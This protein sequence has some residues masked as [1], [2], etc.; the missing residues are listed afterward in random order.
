[1]ITTVSVRADFNTSTGQWDGDVS[2]RSF[3][4]YCRDEMPADRKT[5]FYTQLDQAEQALAARKTNDAEAAMGKALSAVYRGGAESDI[6]VKCLGEP[7][8]RRW[9]NAKLALQRLA[10]TPELYVTAADHGSDGLVDVVSTYSATRFVQSIRTIEGISSRIEA[11]QQ[12]GVFMLP[13]EEDIAKACRD[14]AGPLSQQARRKHQATLAEEGKAFNRPASEQET[15]AANAMGGAGDLASAITGVDINTAYRKETL[16]IQQRVR[17]SKLLLRE[18]RTWNLEHYDNMQSRPTSLRARKRGDVMLEKASDTRLSLGA[19]DEFYESAIAYYEFGGWNK[20]A[21][22]A[23]SA[24][25][26]IQA[27]LKAEQ[28]RQRAEQE[29]A[30]DEMASRAEQMKQAREKMIKT[31][32]EKKSFKEEADALEA[33]L[34][35]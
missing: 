15:A 26:A 17:E 11:E 27:V 2:A 4:E 24:R 16:L 21:T 29:K 31:E 12:Y 8:A 22:K 9:F 32:A 1:M 20:L 34:G 25:D 10:P 5:K 3:A 19:R 6:S 35:L 23:A 18:A 33:E 30:K 14:A 7:S 13:E 28:E